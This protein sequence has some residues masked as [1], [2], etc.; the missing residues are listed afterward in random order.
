MKLLLESNDIELG[1]A[2][3]EL[4]PY[5]RGL[6]E[7]GVRRAL[8][9]HADQVHQEHVLGAVLGDEESAAGQVIEHAFA[10]P[11]TL[12]TE[13]LAL[14]PGLMVVGAKAVLPFSS[15]SL[16][17]LK[18]ARSRALDQARTQLG[19]AG[20]AE[21]CAEALPRAVQ[22]ALGKPDWPHDEGDEGVQAPKRLN[23]DGHLFQG[24]SGAAKRSL[25]RACRS[26]HGRKER[27][28]TSLG[29]LLATLE[30]D[31]ALRSA[32]GWSP[33]KIRSAAEGQTPPASDP[34]EGPLTPSPALAALLTRLPSGADSLDFLAASLAGAEAELAACL[35]R[36]RIT[37]DLVERARGAFRDP[38]GSPPESGC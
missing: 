21:A 12:D 29:L 24:L 16:A 6:V 25:V 19:A 11:E 37:P 34:P 22:E 9:L 10:D 7:N 15:E 3:A 27:S 13:L 4:A 18:K 8:W 26:A 30:E 38:P 31:P 14:S 20:L 23:P 5:L 1:R 32:S 33:G 17:V 28:I 35:S 2:L 36:H